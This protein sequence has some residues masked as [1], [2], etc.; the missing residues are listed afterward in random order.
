MTKENE[1]L[2]IKTE[3]KKEE[4]EMKVEKIFWVLEAPDSELWNEQ[5]TEEEISRLSKVWEIEV[6]DTGEVCDWGFGQ[7]RK[8]VLIGEEENI[9]E[10]K[11]QF[12]EALS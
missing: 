8:Y 4:R 10:F 11:C 2:I 7:E 12:E 3:R 1:C 9:E 6:I 5:D